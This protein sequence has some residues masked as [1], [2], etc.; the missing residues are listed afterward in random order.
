[1]SSNIVKK[2]HYVAREYLRPFCFESEKER[3]YALDKNTKKYF[4]NNIESISQENYFYDFNEESEKRITKKIKEKIPN[5][6]RENQTI[7]G[8]FTE[9]E[10][11]AHIVLKEL[12]ENLEKNLFKKF[13]DEQKG[14]IAA[15]VAV[16]II[17]T[18]KF[19][20]IIIT[21]SEQN[22]KRIIYEHIK[23][24]FPDNYEIKE[25]NFDVKV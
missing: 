3:I 18:R 22:Q 25:D 9:L 21:H 13:T 15:Y 23:A 24:E 6:S 4:T 7:D 2:Q 20:N 19:R 16:Q 5:F 1:M 8:L 12:R 14:N 17:R 11:S 10:K